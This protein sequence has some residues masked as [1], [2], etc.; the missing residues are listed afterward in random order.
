MTSH[1]KDYADAYARFVLRN[2]RAVIFLLFAST[3]LALFFIDRVNLRNDPDSLLPLSN[4]YIATNLYSDLTYGMGNLMVWGMKVKQGDIYQPWFVRMVDEF[5]R[6]VS[7]LAFANAINFVGLPSPKLRNLGITTDG[8]LDFRRLMPANGLASDEQR[9]QEQ[10]DYLR[11]GLEKHLVLEPLLIYYQDAQGNKCEMIGADGLISNDSIRHVH[12][13]CTAVG[14]FIIGD[15][16]NELKDHHL[17]WIAAAKHVMADYQTRYG[18]RVE[19]TISGEPYFLASMVEELWDKAWLFGISLLII[20]LVLWYEF[21]HWSCALLPLLGVG[22]TIILTLGLMGYTQFRLTTMMALTPMLLLAIGIG[23]SMQI[24]RRFMQELHNTGDHEQA[25]L[26]AIRYT[27]VP[28]ALSIGTD[29]HGFFAISFIDISFYKAYAYFGIFGMSTLIL[30]TT[31]LI[32]LLMVTFPPNLHDKEDERGW[33]K[34]LA[35]GLTGMLTGP[36]KWIPVVAVIGIWLLSANLAELDRGFAALLA[37]EAGRADP[38]IARI[39]DEFDIMPG[40][41]KGIHYP[42]AA[43]KDHYLLGE[44]LTGNGEVKAIA[45]LRSLSS[46]MPGVITANM[47]IRSKQGT[48]PPCGVDAWNEAGERVLDADHCFD[49]LEDPPQGIFNQAEVLGALSTF[50]DWLRSHPNIGY[51]ASYV[52]FAK[53]LNMMLNAPTGELPMGHMNLFAIPTIEHMRNNAYAYQLSAHDEQ[54]PDPDQTVQL[55]NGMLNTSAEAGELDS[56]VNTRSWDEGIIIG[57]VNTMDPKQTHQTILDIQR[58]L[59]DHGSDPGMDQLTVGIEGG[60]R[61]TIPSDN[62]AGTRTII[63]GD[64]IPGKA[65]IGGFLGVTE[66]T[67]DVAF[68]EWLNAPVATSLTVFLMTL[69][70]FRSW[71]IACIL[72]SLCFITLMTQYG[73]GAYMT[74]I[75]EWSANLAFHVQVALSIAM[76]LGVDYGVYMVSRL[77]EEMRASGEDWQAALQTTLETTGSAIIISMVVLLGSFIPLMNTELANLWS[78]SLYI[79]EALIMDVIIALMVLPLMV[80]WLRPRFVFGK[81]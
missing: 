70:M 3:L 30:T 68:K 77:R 69:I 19:F 23:H 27:V 73:L 66:A 49:E 36:T 26:A 46:M 11:D 22:M 12:E 44:L 1:T 16:S 57:F 35:K 47:V 15:F 52:Q 79:S 8:S 53:T 20:L 41:E 81:E 65:A 64:T 14:T 50:E 58:Y 34:W 38:E 74:S 62:K 24:T 63:T 13:H 76:G 75:G 59:H 43:Y 25:A 4:R 45:D 60:E 17:D 51:T 32:P 39:Q 5:Y 37:G 67:R 7:G 31:T 10:L 42:R 72:I 29:L 54:F 18:D 40:V 56:F 21:R 2:R 61:I 48:L 9:Q 6:D 33:E 71:M 78:V 55:Y 28:A 80:Y